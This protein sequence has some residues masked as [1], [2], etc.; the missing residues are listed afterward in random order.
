MRVGCIYVEFA[1]LRV[2]FGTVDDSLFNLR[3]LVLGFPVDLTQKVLECVHAC[4]CMCICAFMCVDSCVRAC[5]RVFVCACVPVYVRL[6][7][8]VTVSVCYLCWFL[9]VCVR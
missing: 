6:S 2:F 8:C 9:H 1:L 7:M 5:M 4:V 3:T